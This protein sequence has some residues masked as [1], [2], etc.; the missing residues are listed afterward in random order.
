LFP[1]LAHPPGKLVEVRIY[2]V[3]CG[4]DGTRTG[5]KAGVPMTPSP[6]QA[7]RILKLV[8]VFHRA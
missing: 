3:D 1:S 7:Q 2:P 5:A 4:S 6:E 8:S